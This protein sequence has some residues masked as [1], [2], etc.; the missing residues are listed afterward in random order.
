M[1]PLENQETEEPKPEVYFTYAKLY[2]ELNPNL[3]RLKQKA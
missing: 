3:G 2:F 1:P